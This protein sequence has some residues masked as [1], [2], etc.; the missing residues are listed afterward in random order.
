M[1]DLNFPVELRCTCALGFL[2]EKQER[3]CSL[4]E[5][6]ENI[7]A[8]RSLG[9]RIRKLSNYL[10]SYSMDLS[11]PV[12]LEAIEKLVKKHEMRLFTEE[13]LPEESL[14][15][16]TQFLRLFKTAKISAPPVKAEPQGLKPF[17]KVNPH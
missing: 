12:N 16:M 13:D 7:S 2:E 6:E 14:M 4:S 5:E 17:K 11:R 10:K 3:F 15:K 8:K 9:Q 1:N